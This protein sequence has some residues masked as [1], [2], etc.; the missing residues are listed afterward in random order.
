M[1]SHSDPGKTFRVLS[2]DGGGIK[3]TYTAAFLAELEDMTGARVA[4]HF[5]LIVGTST[6]GIIALALGLGLPAGRILEFYLDRGP[7][8]FPMMS[9]SAR[10]RGIARQLWRPKHSS[11]P[12]RAALEEV[13]A[14]RLLGESSVRLVIP[15]YDGSSGDVHLFKTSHHERFE[16]DHSKAA[17]EVALAT[18]AAP[19]FLSA[20]TGSKGPTL[21]DGGVWANCPAA[22]AVIETLTVL[23]R[24]PGTV[25]LLSVGTTEAPLHVPK[26]K[27]VG[28]FLQ[29][30]LF[31]PELLMQ[32]QAKGAL[33]HAKLLTHGRMVRITE[34]VAPGR[35]AM[36]D[37]RWIQDLRALGEKAARHNKVVIG[38]R[39]LKEPAEP[40]TPFHGPRSKTTAG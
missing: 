13:F 23:G 1:S 18:S 4:D 7:S 40:F 6:G 20:F 11:G 33:A 19:T 5:D 16:R 36:D 15:S 37:P 30:V 9:V 3:G 27:A 21:V 39:F 34:Q 24:R 25:D 17:V 12:L 29:W 26:G 35:F 8:I 2:L 14:G 38:P 31:A 10:L 22:V 28:G 32:A